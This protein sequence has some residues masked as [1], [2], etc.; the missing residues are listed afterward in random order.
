LPAAAA[1]AAA[2]DDD[3]T[4]VV[5]MTRGLGMHSVAALAPCNGHLLRSWHVQPITATDLPY[6]R[7]R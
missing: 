1:A 5:S 3:D 6:I 4:D 7:R 2:A